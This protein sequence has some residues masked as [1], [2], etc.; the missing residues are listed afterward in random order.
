VVKN[1]KGVSSASQIICHKKTPI[2]STPPSSALVGDAAMETCSVNP[3]VFLPEGMTIDQGLIDH[4]AQTWWCP[5][6]SSTE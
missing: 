3:L 1:N 2:V 4:N 6:S 5:S